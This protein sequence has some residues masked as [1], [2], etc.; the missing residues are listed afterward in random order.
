MVKNDM[1]PI[2][3]LTSI[4][5]LPNAV[6]LRSIFFE[7]FLEE[8]RKYRDVE[9][10]WLVYLPIKIHE[11]KKKDESILDI[12]NFDDAVEVLRERK[13]DLVFTHAGVGHI[14][15]A[16]L[17]AAKFLKIPTVC[18]MQNALNP[19]KISQTNLIKSY[20]SGFFANS[21]PADPENKI[22]F[23]RGRFFFYKWIFLIK[24]QRKTNISYIKIIKKFFELLKIYLTQTKFKIVPK[25]AGTLNWIQS[26]N[27]EKS[28]LKS[29]F[30]K[31]SL[32]VIGDP[33][34]DKIFKKIDLIKNKQK[35]KKSILFITSPHVEHGLITKQQRKKLVLD[36]VKNIVAHEEEF[37]LKIK[38]HP[39][40]ENII[41]YQALLKNEGYDIPIFQKGE[42]MDFIEDAD[43][44]ISFSIA[45]TANMFAL[46][47]KKPIVIYDYFGIES[48]EFFSRKLVYKCTKSSEIIPA[49]FN[50]A[51]KNLSKT[52]NSQKFL[53]E[54][55]YKLDG[56]A[57][58][59]LTDKILQLIENDKRIK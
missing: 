5:T 41:E 49:I 17:T 37:D 16:L 43:I 18:G 45:T 32:H 56:N 38:I 14:T 10:N 21:I 25:Y 11:N 20:L 51:S 31:S 1:P 44:I 35:N 50:T 33:T 40:S 53:E 46:I 47:A 29:G 30:E 27:L 54:F 34:Y 55:F 48:G 59:R 52:E 58:K 6:S 26:K 13:P 39:S 22:L 3:I 8:I 12:H 28:L 23:V 57:S 7:N 9:I 19:V 2:R 42:I 4:H 15:L 24:T 36:I